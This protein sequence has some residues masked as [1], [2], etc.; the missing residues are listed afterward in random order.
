MEK[1]GHVGLNNMLS[2]YDD[3]SAQAICTFA[4]TEGPGKEVKIFQ[5]VQDVCL[6]N[7][8]FN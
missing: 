2:A 3:K 4:F 5:G 1:V 6:L 8:Q 7:N